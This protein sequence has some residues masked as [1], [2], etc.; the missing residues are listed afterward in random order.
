M[1]AVMDKKDKHLLGNRLEVMAKD[2]SD[3]IAFDDHKIKFMTKYCRGQHVLDI[4]CVMHN[5]ENYKSRFWLHKALLKVTASLEGFDL[6]EDGIDYLKS[7]NFN[8]RV[9]DAQAFSLGKTFDVITAGDVIEHLNNIEG[10]LRSCKKHMHE[11]SRLLISTPNPWY[12]RNIVKAIIYG[13]VQNNPE[14]TCW[15]CPVTLRQLVNRFGLDVGEVVFGSRYV[16]D[17]LI[18]LPYGIKHTSFH[19]EVFLKK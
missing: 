11:N 19:A 14:H 18:P 4:G 17:R 2:F 7:H 10:F 12:W 8:V 13:E 5:P 6:Y 3:R 1:G 15:L 9:A 16:K